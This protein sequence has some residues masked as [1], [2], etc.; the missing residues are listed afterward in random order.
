MV[1]AESTRRAGRY[2]QRYR[3]VHPDGKTRWIH[4]QWEVKNGPRGVPD[5]ALGVMMD[6]TEAYEA[7]RTL[8]DVNAQL[9][10][11]ADLG[12]IGSWRRDLRTGRMHFSDVTFE[13]LGMAPRP[14]GLAVDEVQSLIHP[15]DLPLVKASIEQVLATNQ[16]VDMEAR[17]RRADGSWRYLLSR[18]VVE[19]NQ[20]GEPIAFVGVSLDTT[21]RV[22]HLRHAE[23]LARR[24]DAASRAAGIGIWTTTLGSGKHGLER[25]DVRAV[26]PL[27]AAARA[28]LSPMAPRDGPS[29][30][31][32]PRR[33]I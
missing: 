4:S 30:R 28:A 16:P 15:D 23:E 12:K 19:R 31:P 5:R 14:E 21:E 6:D 9:K 7:A 3:V 32:G 13:L 10:L 8:S 25:P 20:A 27:R 2:S 11:A 26:R 17:Y 24:L 18:R 1:Y 33:P 29:R 22:E